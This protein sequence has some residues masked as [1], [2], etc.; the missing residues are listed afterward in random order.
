[1][2]VEPETDA[3]RPDL[4]YDYH[5]L[6]LDQ[7]NGSWSYKDGFGGYIFNE[8]GDGKP[9]FNPLIFN[10][11]PRHRQDQDFLGE[12]LGGDYSPYVNAAF[13]CAPSGKVVNLCP[14]GAPTCP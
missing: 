3:G 1:M 7:E 12:R 13:F 11:L 14:A 8:D 9:I 6:R 4:A 5:F 10:K 2:M